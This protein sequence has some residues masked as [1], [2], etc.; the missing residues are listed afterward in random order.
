MLIK[1]RIFGCLNYEL[2]YTVTS[3]FDKVDNFAFVVALHSG[4]YDAIQ[5]RVV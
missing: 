1:N 5:I 2:H 4:E 3:V